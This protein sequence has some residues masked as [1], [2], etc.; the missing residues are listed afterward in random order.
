MDMRVHMNS[1]SGMQKIFA[2]DLARLSCMRYSYMKYTYMT[3][4]PHGRYDVHSAQVAL[5]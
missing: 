1:V 2:K 3:Y 5:H 4:L